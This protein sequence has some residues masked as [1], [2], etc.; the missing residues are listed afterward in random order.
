MAYK[1]IIFV[2]LFT[3]ITGLTFGQQTN[4]VIDSLNIRLK[5]AADTS[6]VNIL[7]DIAFEYVSE[8]PETAN[9][10]SNEAL[11]LSENLN[12]TNGQIIA[13]NNLGLAQYYSNNYD[14]ALEYYNKVFFAF[15]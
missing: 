4:K 2:S 8:S 15:Q 12:F 7:N 10:Y 5:S 9:K 3:F 14:K 6:R 1:L 11:K 13:Y